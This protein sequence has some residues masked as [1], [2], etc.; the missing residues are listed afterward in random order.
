MK[1]QVK[2]WDDNFENNKSRERDQCS[3]VCVPNKQD[4]MGLVWIL[5]EPDGAAI[6]GI[7][8]LIIGACSRQS[9]PRHGYLTDN[10]RADGCPWTV[11]DMA[12]RW[13]RPPS[14]IQRSIDVLL[15]P[16][17]G[18]I[19]DLGVDAPEVPA[20][21][22]PDALEGN[23]RE[24]KGSAPP[25]P[26]GVFTQADVAA[27]AGAYPLKTGLKGAHN[28]IR[29][30]LTLLLPRFKTHAETVAWLLGRVA[31]FAASHA[32]QTTSK[33][34]RWWFADGCYDDDPA[35]WQPRA[36]NKPADKEEPRTYVDT[37]L[38]GA[39][40]E[41]WVKAHQK[42]GVSHAKP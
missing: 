13:R 25:A 1:L 5:S 15:S 12:L 21:C 7:W 16:K 18:W 26:V 17:V 38:T 39:A 37:P 22:P 11:D 3:F 24:E 32:G 8:N 31:A 27:I 9:R 2:D 23:R 41:S 28:S 42:N 35:A 29:E 30:T 33:S 6:Y 14:E 20:E 4:G 40:L 34:A 10:G 19:I 36:P